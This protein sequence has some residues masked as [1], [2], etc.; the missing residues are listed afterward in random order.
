VWYARRSASPGAA[1]AFHRMM[2]ESDVRD[3]LPSV[4]APTLILHRP[5]TRDE[6]VYVAERI[7]G[8]KRVEIPGV[9]DGFSWSDPERN[10]AML[11]EIELFLSDLSPVRTSDRV[12]ATLLFSDIVD[13]TPQ[14]ASIG[15]SAWRELISRHNAVFRGL[16][17]RYQGEEIDSSGDGFFASF[18]GPGRAIECAR[19]LRQELGALGLEVRIGIHTGECERIDR[20]LG[21]IAVPI[22]A[23]IMG[24]AGAGEVLV[25]STVRDL[26]AGSGLEF[27]DRGAHELKGVPGE[28]R[29]YAVRDA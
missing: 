12:L 16:L 14:A 18:D 15:D 9:V 21:G 28:W 11:R 4:R 17:A 22:G 5:R 13:S 23:R 19:A 3:V 25:S 7:P 10:A 26:V 6:A 1:V 27:E 20:K 2:M 8:A 29:L 24:L